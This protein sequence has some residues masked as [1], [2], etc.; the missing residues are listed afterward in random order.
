MGNKRAIFFGISLLL[1]SLFILSFVF[2]EEIISDSFNFT[3]SSEL[4]SEY[5]SL[6][7]DFSE[8]TKIIT[9]D[10]QLVQELNYE[11]LP[12]TINI[13]DFNSTGLAIYQI[14]LLDSVNP[15]LNIRNIGINKLN[16]F[17]ETNDTSP[18]GG[19]GKPIKK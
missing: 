19:K 6:V 5:E 12:S 16:I 11:S 3:F 1:V 2:A 7:I 15:V 18:G 10:V 8:D 17:N 13:T 9:S 14:Y 4:D